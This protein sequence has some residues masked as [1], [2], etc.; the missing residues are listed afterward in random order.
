MCVC[1][2]RAGP[3]WGVCVCVCVCALNRRARRLRRPSRSRVSRPRSR[4]TRLAGGGAG[5][6][7]GH[8]ASD[9]RARALMEASPCPA[10]P[11]DSDLDAE[12]DWM[13]E[14]RVVGVAVRDAR[15]PGARARCRTRRAAAHAG[16]P[17]AE[18]AV[19]EM[20]RIVVRAARSGAAAASAKGSSACASGLAGRAREVER[21]HVLVDHR[22]VHV[23]HS[24]ART[25]PRAARVRARAACAARGPGD[26]RTSSRGASLLLR[27]A[28]ATWRTAASAPSR[29]TRVAVRRAPTRRR[30]R[31]AAAAARARACF[32]GSP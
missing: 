31:R 25:A 20:E 14:R 26:G 3:V 8:R 9:P 24:A 18:E 2:A 16:A 1:A 11:L 7:A 21:H 5:R 29:S 4:P 13:G 22:V 17:F 19:R 30:R 6:R 28:N 15:A 27:H 32:A 12:G 10:T 23:L